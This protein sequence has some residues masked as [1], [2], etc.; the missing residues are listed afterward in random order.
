MALKNVQCYNQI[1]IKIGI[2]GRYLK[3]P[4]RIGDTK[5]TVHCNCFNLPPSTA[6]EQI[7]N[8]VTPTCLR[9]LD[10]AITERL[11]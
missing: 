1:V 10:D 11:R 5:T 6:A 7:A 8:D 3:S 4:P 9:Y 2:T